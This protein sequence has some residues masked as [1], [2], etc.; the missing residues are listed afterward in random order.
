MH[1]FG[2]VLSSAIFVNWM[3]YY[4]L[5]QLETDDLFTDICLFYM[6]HSLIN[7]DTYATVC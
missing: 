5:D 6:C 4:S 3:I 1:Q 2:S 7:S